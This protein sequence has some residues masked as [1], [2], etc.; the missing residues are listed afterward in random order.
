[1]NICSGEESQAKEETKTLPADEQDKML[2]NV[3][4]QATHEL[5]TVQQKTREEVQL[6]LLA[7]CQKLSDPEL[8]SKVSNDQIVENDDSSPIEIL[9]RNSDSTPR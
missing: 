5:T 6:F 1:M 2:C 3:I 4:V 9:V 8:V 7:D